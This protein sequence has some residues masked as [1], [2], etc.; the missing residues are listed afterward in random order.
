MNQLKSVDSD[1]H[2]F[3]TMEWSICAN[4]ENGDEIYNGS[5]MSQ[6][7]SRNPN[8]YCWKTSSQYGQSQFAPYYSPEYGNKEGFQQK[9]SSPAYQSSVPYKNA[10]FVSDQNC[11]LSS[12][13]L[14]PFSPT[15]FSPTHYESCA[16]KGLKAP[17]AFSSREEGHGD[18]DSYCFNQTCG[19]QSFP[20]GQK[21]YIDEVNGS[22]ASSCGNS[23]AS[24]I[25]GSDDK[26]FTGNG[27]EGQISSSPVYQLSPDNQSKDFPA[28]IVIPPELPSCSPSGFKYYEETEYEDG[29]NSESLQKLSYLGTNKVEEDNALDFSQ[30]EYD[31]GKMLWKRNKMVVSVV[32]DQIVNLYDVFFTKL[33]IAMESLGRKELHLQNSKLKNLRRNLPAQTT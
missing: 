28:N 4:L 27:F 24:S 29:R 22:P 7:W 18:T 10:Y 30:N 11:S 12:S 32:L 17:N 20:N 31:F 21:T 9:M 26:M 13:S 8:G 5:G 2:K 14:S 3:N 23:S 19:F 1:I 33:Q 16:I 6:P 25:H 15:T